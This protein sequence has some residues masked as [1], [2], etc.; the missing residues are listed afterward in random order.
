MRPSAVHTIYNLT[1]N[2]TPSNEGV[3]WNQQFKETLEWKLKVTRLHATKIMLSKLK[4]KNQG[5]ND[6]ENFVGEL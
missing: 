6:V 3:L 4:H 5:T 1:Y 2:V